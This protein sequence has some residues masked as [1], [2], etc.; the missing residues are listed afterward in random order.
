MG[1][2]M[3]YLYVLLQQQSSTFA[4]AATAQNYQAGSL[5]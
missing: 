4:E 3:F 1:C 5:P 2:I